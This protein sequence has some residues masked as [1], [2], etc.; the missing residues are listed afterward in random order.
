MAEVSFD[1]G[2]NRWRIHSSKNL[3]PIWLGKWT[4]TVVDDEQRVLATHEFDYEEAETAVPAALE[5]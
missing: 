2:G 3:Q 4:V 1:V 5:E